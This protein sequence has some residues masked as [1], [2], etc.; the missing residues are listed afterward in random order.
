L[1]R[2]LALVQA[3][4]KMLVAEN[5]K[6]RKDQVKCHCL[7]LSQLTPVVKEFISDQLQN[8]KKRRPTWSRA[9]QRLAIGLLHYS[10]RSHRFMRDIGFLLPCRSTIRQKV[11]SCVRNSGICPTIENSVAAAAVSMTEA[12]KVCTISFDGM[13]IR[14]SLRFDSNTDQIIGFE[15]CG[16]CA[17]GRTS[18]VANELVVVWIRGV[19]SKWKQPVGFYLL[20]H[21]PGAQRFKQILTESVAAVARMG[22]KACAIVCD[23]E[24]TQWKCI[25]NLGANVDNPELSIE[26][27][28]SIVRIPA[29]VDVPHCLKNMRNAL[30]K[31]LIHFYDNGERKIACWADIL[32]VAEAELSRPDNL[33]LVPKLKEIHVNLTVGKN[34]SVKLAAQVLS[35]MMAQA[36][37]VY[38]EFGVIVSD[39][40]LHTARFCELVN[41]LFDLSNGRLSRD[42]ITINNRD[43]KNSE[44]DYWCDW[45]QGLEFHKKDGVR[46][47]GIKFSIGWQLS[48]RSIQ[49]IAEQALHA[50]SW[51]KVM[52]RQLTQD[53]VENGFSCIRRR[54]GFNDRPE[55]REAVAAL[56]SLS[57]NQL[58]GCQSQINSNCKSDGST[59]LSEFQTHVT[60]SASVP[61][62]GPQGDDPISAD[63][64]ASTEEAHDLPAG[65]FGSIES[66]KCAYIG[67]WLLFKLFKSECKCEECQQDLKGDVSEET[68][69]L[70]L[71]NG[72][73]GTGN[74][75]IPNK[76]VI[77]AV[78]Q[79]ERTFTTTDKGL[80]VLKGVS[81]RLQ[82]K[83]FPVVLANIHTHSSDHSERCARAMAKLFARLRL[84]HW[85][86]SQRELAQKRKRGRTTGMKRTEENKK[87]VRMNAV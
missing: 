31:Y 29:V 66:Q 70:Q 39:T 30:M 13:A 76:A 74:L 43:A 5:A 41:A 72:Q 26:M 28:G 34:M 12:E 71:K 1:N 84:H 45:L 27:N 35:R 21:A 18:T 86:N 67:G 82:E 78:C 20:H 59:L 22:L 56:R 77:S 81:Q 8:S 58:L 55:C 65:T 54:G 63:S 53:H 79:M 11:G 50:D 10:P 15:D 7:R 14:P 87:M 57:V 49:R 46:V 25:R 62:P 73:G 51:E 64:V 48:L 3:K 60:A 33:R 85:C 6:L 44:I 9:T 75:V 36:L 17:G 68:R 42:G 61:S 37:R 24:A 16:P 2:K 19:C 32:A 52:V 4:Y 38:V 69:F 47:N 23:Q 80:F 40:A 83:F